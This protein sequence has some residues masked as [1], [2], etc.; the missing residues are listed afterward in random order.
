MGTRRDSFDEIENVDLDETLTPTSNRTGISPVK[1]SSQLSSPA[2][3]NPEQYFGQRT[4]RRG[5]GGKMITL[6]TR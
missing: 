6:I 5:N 3:S 4:D 1:Y 2:T